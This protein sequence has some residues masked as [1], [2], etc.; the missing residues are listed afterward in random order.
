L[1][2]NDSQRFKD[3]NDTQFE[4]IDSKTK[5]IVFLFFLH[6]GRELAGFG[7]VGEE[8]GGGDFEEPAVEAQGA[9]GEAVLHA[10]IAVQIVEAEEDVF[11]RGG[12]AAGIE[13]V[14]V[15]VIFFQRFQN[16]RGE[17]EPV[18]QMGRPLA[19]GRMVEQHGNG[20]A[21]GMA[22]DDDVIHAQP[23]HGKFNGGS[24]G[25]GVAAG[26]G[27]WDDVADVFD[28]KEIAGLAVGDEFGQDA[29]I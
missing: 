6:E 11:F 13:I 3:A 9:V 14:E 10:G 1:S 15:S 28:N 25:I 7:V 20:A 16:G 12:G 18:A 5:V 17:F 4:T 22:A 23:V 24:G 2:C 21:L 29:G 27:G 26:R 8:F 19:D